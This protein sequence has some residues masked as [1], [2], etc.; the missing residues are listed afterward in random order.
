[1]LS[2][3]K[4]KFIRS[5]QLKKNREESGCFVVEGQKSVMELI[6]SHFQIETVVCTEEFSRQNKKS[7]DGKKFELTLCGPSELESASAFK[8]ANS[9]LAVARVRPD[10]FPRELLGL[11]LALDGVRNPGNLGSIVRIADWFGIQTI[12]ASKD[13]ADFYN[14]KVLQASMGSFCRVPVHYVNLEEIFNPDFA[15]GVSLPLYAASPKGDSVH[16]FEFKKDCVLLLGNESR[17]ISNSLE[18]FIYRAIGIPGYGSAESLN[19]STAAAII[20]DNYR[21]SS[22]PLSLETRECSDGE[23]HSLLPQ[24][25]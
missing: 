7:L 17:G 14:P 11:T 15:L 24:P 16:N 1:M 23:Q 2:K 25:T 12:L 8:T 21:R 4:A 9:A 3:N 20:C 22:K 13:T 5:L 19:I 10:I 6:N 18:G